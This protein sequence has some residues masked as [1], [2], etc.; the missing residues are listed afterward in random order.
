MPHEIPFF[1]QLPDAR[2]R[3]ARARIL[4]TDLDG[5]LLGAGGSLLRDGAGTP[6]L[7]GATAVV[8]VNSAGLPVVITSGRN[9]K[10][11]TEVSRLLGW[12]DFIAEV[13]TIRSYDNGAR[14]IYDLGVW[15]DG[16]LEAGETPFTAIERAGAVAL[17]QAR[18]P[19][20]VEYH[21]PWHRDREVTHMLR[22]KLPIEEA[23]ALLDT[24]PLPVTIVDN[25][26]IRPLSHGLQAMPEIH[27]IHL[28]PSGASKE[29]AIAADLAER[30]FT[31]DQA[32]AIGDGTA[33]IGMADAVGLMVCVRNGLDDPTLLAA[34]VR[35]TNIAATR[36]ARGEGWR[37]L[38]GAW[39]AARRAN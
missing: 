18:Y 14:R 22:G 16:A 36:G 29:R 5:T 3:L 6:T 23:Q 35:H 28:V 9:V 27:A 2:E 7:D 4:Y 10:Q 39:I 12:R 24:L 38:V 21:D 8:E 1:D 20:L 30:G 31:R 32:L 26:I 25:G 19:G 13:G 11:L 15:P 17:L 34:A 37:E 33:D